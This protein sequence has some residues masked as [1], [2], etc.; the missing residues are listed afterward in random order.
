M[1]LHSS[2]R[3]SL[4]IVCV[5][6]VL[7]SITEAD[8]ALLQ[9]QAAQS[10]V[11]R[12][13]G[14]VRDDNGLGL[15][16]GWC[17]PGEFT[18]GSPMNEKGRGDDEHQVHVTLT[19]GFWM[20]RHEVTQ[21]QWQRVMQS[22]PWRATS[23]HGPEYLKDGND[24]PAIIVSWLDATKFCETLTQQERRAGRLPSGW[25]YALPT[26]A[27]WEYACRGGSTF[28][29]SFGDDESQLD[30]YAWWGILF[31]NANVKREEYA[32]V[33]GQK[34]PNPLGLSDMHGNVYEWCRDWYAKQLPGGT[35]PQ[36]PAKGMGR[37]IRGG[38][39]VDPAAFCRS[40]DRSRGKPD[41]RS[42]DLGFRLVAVPMSK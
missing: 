32:H 33:V 31:G 23:R 1:R 2:C 3:I 35:D 13:A 22:T 21:G 9:E 39:W 19:N 42:S 7:H 17:P 15:K 14:Q 20:G 26:E 18:M 24:Y 41:F 16:L 27:Q 29:F 12:I 34:K 5:V 37:V 11:G 30:D 38:S 4:Q 28:R 10:F 8:D 25:R 40:A 6:A 36:G